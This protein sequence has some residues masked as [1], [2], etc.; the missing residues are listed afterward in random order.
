MNAP[1]DHIEIAARLMRAREAV[2]AGQAI[3]PADAPWMVGFLDRVL[4]GD[5]LPTAIGVE[6][7]PGR[8]SWQTQHRASERD[9]LLRR[10]FAEFYSSWLPT[11]AADQI[12]RHWDRYETSGIAARERALAEC[13]KRH[14]GSAGEI[15]W[16]LAQLG[17]PL[18]IGE[19]Q[20]PTL[21][22]ESIRKILVR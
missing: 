22:A 18:P 12:A 13:P 6:T 5:D 17:P 2:R 15:I 7:A 19:K 4:A 3:P 20:R 10:I 1:A 8:R 9:W 11:P 16:K 21:G 14:V